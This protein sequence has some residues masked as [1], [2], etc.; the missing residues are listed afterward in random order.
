MKKLYRIHTLFAAI[1]LRVILLPQY[2]CDLHRS[3]L[4]RRELKGHTESY[5]TS[6]DATNHFRQLKET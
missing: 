2:V 6:T 3:E 5:N 1:G 4:T